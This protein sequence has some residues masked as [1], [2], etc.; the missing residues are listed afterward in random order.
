MIP[1]VMSICICAGVCI[2]G[3][4]QKCIDETLNIQFLNLEVHRMGSSGDLYL[5]V[6]RYLTGICVFFPLLDTRL[7]FKFYPMVL[8]FQG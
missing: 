2:L 8:V 3:T 1:H 7:K 4:P 6:K 5:I